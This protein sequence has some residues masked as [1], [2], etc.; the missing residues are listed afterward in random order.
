M[1]WVAQAVNIFETGA[2][3]SDEALTGAVRGAPSASSLNLA[4]AGR[5]ALGKGAGDAPA[6]LADKGKAA[7]GD[8]G[9]SAVPTTKPAKTPTRGDSFRP[10]P[11]AQ[12]RGAAL[13]DDAVEV[14]ALKKQVESLQKVISQGGD[15]YKSLLKEFDDVTSQLAKNNKLT[16]MTITQLEGVVAESVAKQAKLAAKA[17]ESAAT[18]AAKAA[19]GEAFA[20]IMKA[21]AD[22]PGVAKKAAAK[23][24]SPPPTLLS[25]LAYYKW[26]IATMITLGL[27]VPASITLALKAEEN[28]RRKRKLETTA[29]G[30]CDTYCL[31]IEY[32]KYLTKKI[33]KADLSNPSAAGLTDCFTD[34][35]TCYPN[36]TRL[37][38]KYGTDIKNLPT[39]YCT[40]AD[41]DSCDDKCADVCA[42]KYPGSRTGTTTGTRTGAGTDDEDADWRDPEPDPESKE[43]DYTPYIWGG[44]ILL[45]IIILIAMASRGSGD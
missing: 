17:S 43:T 38:K 16:R 19:A 29:A 20:D 24:K 7:L 4:D 22:A 1:G 6:N 14:A 36:L 15:A 37:Q 26:T 25:K 8:T 30:E 18:P 3:N 10:P 9:R 39:Y 42:S 11:A 45:L 31:P 5:G 21:T 2:K 33:T 40:E 12:Q 27:V 44:A 35:N 23:L 32:D 13:V 41:V 28:R 34:D